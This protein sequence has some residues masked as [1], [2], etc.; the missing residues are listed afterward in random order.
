MHMKKILLAVVLF[1]SLLLMSCVGGSSD[2][3]AISEAEKQVPVVS[4]PLLGELPSW[5]KQYKAARDIVK[6]EFSEKVKS[7]SSDDAGKA[8]KEMD[9]Y[10]KEGKAAEEALKQY[11]EPRI[12]EA[13]GKIIGTEIPCTFDAARYSSAKA[14][15]TNVEDGAVMIK[16]TLTLSAPLGRTPYVL[17]K[18]NNAEGSEITSGAYYPDKGD[19]KAGSVVEAGLNP[20]KASN[21]DGV[22]SIYFTK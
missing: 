21:I 17:W 22:A 6:Q 13:G 7:I 5:Q 19:Y 4:S 2:N 10:D 16:A 8:M 1:P 15:I 20:G 11:Y 18:Y 9:K 12:K 3:K 14:V